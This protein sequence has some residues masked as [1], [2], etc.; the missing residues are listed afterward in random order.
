MTFPV[1]EIQVKRESEDFT[2][3]IS[4]KKFKIQHPKSGRRKQQ[5]EKRDFVEINEDQ[6]IHEN[7]ILCNVTNNQILTEEEDTN[8]EQ[9]CDQSETDIISNKKEISIEEFSCEVCGKTTTTSKNY[10]LK[11]DC[12]KIYQCHVC[13]NEFDTL[14][15]LN[16]HV[17]ECEIETSDSEIYGEKDDPDWE[18]DDNKISKVEPERTMCQI[19]KKEFMTHYIKKHIE[20]VHEGK[21]YPVSTV[22]CE[23]C[24]KNVRRGSIKK[25]VE[26]VH[27]GVKPY[28]C[29]ICNKAFNR[30]RMVQRHVQLFH[31]KQKN[32]VCDLCGK[33]FGTNDSFKRH[34]ENIHEGIINKVT[35]ELCNKSF[36]RAGYLRKHI[37]IMHEGDR[38]FYK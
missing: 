28:N 1:Q 17:I 7:L 23:I 21:K 31:E 18:N 11:N 5:L 24:G 19:C 33:S 25:H 6:E 13:V 34:K 27:E 9:K 2:D 32:F 16:T 10:H 36:T 30:E 29:K 38:T 20:V 22:A 26:W 12:K 4:A 8:S 37:K 15:E 3:E 35:C 14:F